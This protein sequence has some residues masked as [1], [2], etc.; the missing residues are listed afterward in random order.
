[1]IGRADS[2]FA[3]ANVQ[4]GTNAHILKEMKR[5]RIKMAEKGAATQTA[6]DSVSAKQSVPVR[7]E[8][9][10]LIERFNKAYDEIANR[11]FS[12][13]ENDGRMFGRDLENWFKAETG[14]FHPVHVSVAEAE[15]IV[16]VQAEV[17]GF[18]VKDL[19]VTLE[20][21]RLII[22]GKRETKEETQKGKTVYKE[23]CSNE[24]FRAVALPA[25]VDASKATATLKNGVLELQ[26]PKS[27]KATASRVE[28]KTA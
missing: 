21:K 19:E 23:Q 18:E 27:A 6:L 3:S 25:E 2:S 22:S 13:F 15:G 9:K 26:A 17:P 28:V 10:D 14:L 12:I 11:A 20:P 7:S 1:V 16:T 8:S 4:G 5:R 24:I